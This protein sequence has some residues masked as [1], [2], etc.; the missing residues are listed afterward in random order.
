MDY[1][2]QVVYEDNHLLVLNKPAGMLVQGDS[3]GDRPL[4][5]WGKLYLKEKYQKPGKVFLGVVHRIDRPVSGLTLLARTSKALERMNLQ[6]KEREVHKVY[7]AVVTKPP[8]QAEG[9]LQHY[10]IKD[11]Q[12]NKTYAFSQPKKGSK[13]AELY[14]RLIAQLGQKY[15]LEVEPQTGKPHQIRVQLASLGCPIWGDLKYGHDLANPD[16]SISLHAYVLNFQH[17]V[18]KI[19]LRLQVNPPEITVWQE[20]KAYF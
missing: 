3:T 11:A 16:K 4:V 2:F 10:L 17:P 9:K 5:E 14:Y 12:K 15:L 8:P 18:R 19:P 20:F 13:P 7:L 1:P 6:F